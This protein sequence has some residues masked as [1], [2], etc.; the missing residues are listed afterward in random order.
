VRK[1]FICRFDVVRVLPQKGGLGTSDGLSLPIVRIAL[2]QILNLPS[3]CTSSSVCRWTA[4]L[5]SQRVS[6]LAVRDGFFSVFRVAKAFRRVFL[7]VGSR[8]G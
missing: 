2:A 5:T 4:S 1:A 6:F 3:A 7:W 8:L